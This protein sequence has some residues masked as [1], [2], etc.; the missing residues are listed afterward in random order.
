MKYKIIIVGLTLLVLF[1]PDL[2]VFAQ[3]PE[4]EALRKSDR[5]LYDSIMCPLCPGQTISQSNSETSRQ[6]RD[7]V[8]R[9]LRQGDTKEEILEYFANRY[10]ER[11]LAE[12]KKKGFNLMLW[13]LPFIFLA[14]M[15]IVIFLLIRRWSTRVQV[16]TV[17][18]L[19]EAHLAEYKERLEKELKEFDDA[20]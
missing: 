20:F 4:E 13:F 9:K 5:E 2:A 14:L 15:A 7:L 16:E 1:F 10:G 6:M 19:E 8:L 3:A 11:I 17:P 12:P 18:H